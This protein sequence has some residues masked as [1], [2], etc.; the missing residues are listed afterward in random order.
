MTGRIKRLRTLAGMNSRV[1]STA[2]REAADRITA[3]KAAGDGLAGLLDEVQRQG[4]E[5]C[6]G[7][8]ASAM[9][10]VGYCPPKIR[11]AALKQWKES[12]DGL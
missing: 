1:D 7:D 9:P 10:P 3:M 6:S 8:C 12:S 2:M 11:A 4:C 5:V